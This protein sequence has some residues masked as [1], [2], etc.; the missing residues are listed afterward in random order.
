MGIENIMALRGDFP[1]DLPNYKAPEDGFAYASE[2]IAYIRRLG[3]PF[4]VGAACYPEVHPEAS[5]ARDDLRHLKEK[6]EAGS[7]FLISQLFFI[8]ENYFSFLDRCRAAKID[9]PIIPG[10]MPITN[11]K[12]VERFTAM[13]GC[14]FPKQLLEKIAKCDDNK[15]ELY[16][17]SLDYSLEQ[18]QGL[19]NQEVPGI[20]FYTLNQSG[21][22]KEIFKQLG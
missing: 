9:L 17:L 10:I 16:K 1:R 12:Q 20:H 7:D 13:T 11:F 2:L 6:V 3:F 15:E 5:S 14:K 19:L 22:T 21:L 8:N 4:S 18:C